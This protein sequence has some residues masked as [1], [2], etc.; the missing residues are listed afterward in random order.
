M[1]IKK[2]AISLAAA[3]ALSMSLNAAQISEQHQGY[4]QLEA[5]SAKILNQT[6]GVYGIGFGAYSVYLKHLFV[7]SGFNF[8][9]S[10][11]YSQAF[12]NVNADIRIGASFRV[13]SKP[14]HIYGIV[15]PEIQWNK[16]DSG[17]G[18]GF[19]GGVEYR[20]SRDW[21]ASVEY[22]SYSLQSGTSALQYTYSTTMANIRWYW[23]K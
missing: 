8:D 5:G 21:S 20:F 10:H 16:N 13:D 23:K 4:I 2:L 15:S 6:T 12:Y 11:A 7:A 17:D 3:S 9:Y 18:F 14:V 19:G 22:K 1:K